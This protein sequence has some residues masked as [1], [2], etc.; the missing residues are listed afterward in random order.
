MNV[1]NNSILRS[2]LGVVL[3]ILLIMW[4]EIAIT[5]LVIAVGIFFIIPGLYSIISYIFRDRELNAYSPLFPIIGAG[6]LLFGIW[7]V[8]MPN[9]FVGVFMYILGALL[10]I[11]GIQ[12][13]VMLVKARKWSVVPFGY[14][15]IPALIFIIGI[16]ILFYP[17]QAAA[18]T[19][20]IFGVAIMLYGVSE[21]I[22]WYKFRHKIAKL[23]KEQEMFIKE[24]PVEVIDPTY[25]DIDEEL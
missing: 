23:I 19:F 13:T 12:Q 17:F 16:M 6:S 4:P 2:I 18:N 11:A 24:P 10:I 9:F 1:I 22:S 3:G 8:V 15:I 21:L 5:Y 7:L 14:Y 20:I 25:I